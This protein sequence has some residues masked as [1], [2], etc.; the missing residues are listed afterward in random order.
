M[1]KNGNLQWIK[2]PEL[3]NYPMGWIDRQIARQV[4]KK[5]HGIT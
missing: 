5:D 4:G 2:V 3:E 1:S